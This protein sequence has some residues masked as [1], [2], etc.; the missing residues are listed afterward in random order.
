MLN[1][2]EVAAYVSHRYRKIFGHALDEMKL[3]KLLYFAQRESL[4]MFGTPLFPEK[5]EAWKYGPVMRCLRGRSWDT[6]MD[7]ITLYPELPAYIPVFNRIFE[8]YAHKS[9]WTLSSV[10]HGE[11]CWQKAKSKERDSQPIEIETEDIR[12]DA[13]IIR[14]RRMIFN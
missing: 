10:S 5:F 9:S 12:Q 2:Y 11:T 6:E 7:P 8:L 13:E 3:H 4:L 14:L 1:V